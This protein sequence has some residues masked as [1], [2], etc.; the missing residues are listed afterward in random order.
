M[1]TGFA[2]DELRNAVRYFSYM[3][4]TFNQRFTAPELLAIHRYAHAHG[5]I[6]ECA[7]RWDAA[8]LNTALTSAFPEWETEP[9]TGKKFCP[10]CS[11]WQ[12]NTAGPNAHAPRCPRGLDAVT[13]TVPK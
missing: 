12:Y 9:H 11:A 1:K 6:D 13:V 2:I 5:D 4:E 8:T 10:L 3:N 7:D